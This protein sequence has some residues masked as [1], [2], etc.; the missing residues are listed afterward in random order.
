MNKYKDSGRWSS[1]IVFIQVFSYVLTIIASLY[2]DLINLQIRC[3]IK[4]HDVKE[5]YMI[6]MPKMER[7]F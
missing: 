5:K 3:Y 7:S 4:M 6:K 1:N 2:I